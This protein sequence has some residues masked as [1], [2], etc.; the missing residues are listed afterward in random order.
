M[1]LPDVEGFSGSAWLRF[2]LLDYDPGERTEQ[3]HWLGLDSNALGRMFLEYAASNRALPSLVADKAL[4]PLTRYEPNYPIGPMPA[5]SRLQ[6]QG[7][8]EDRPLL[9]QP[10]LR[11]WPHSEILSNTVVEVTVS[12]EGFLISAVVLAECGWPEADRDALNI[13]RG[14]RFQPLSSVSRATAEV[15]PLTWGRIVFY[16]HTLPL[17]ATNHSADLAEP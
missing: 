7:G 6:M 3:P 16:W 11:S 4:P 15:G 1:A 9:A 2:P 10:V 13:V 14:L 12:A 8:L 5:G 17:D